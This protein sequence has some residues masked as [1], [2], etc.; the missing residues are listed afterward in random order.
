[1]AASPAACHVVLPAV[2]AADP[3]RASAAARLIGIPSAWVLREGRAGRPVVVGS[4][5]GAVAARRSAEPLLR[6]GVP[7]EVVIPGAGAARTGLL[8]VGVVI[9]LLAAGAALPAALLSGLGT[10]AVVFGLGVAFAAA[11]VV[12]G[13][14]ALPGAPP[15]GLDDAIARRDADQAR[16]GDV[17]T[18]LAAL[19][20]TLNDTDLPPDAAIELGAEL[21]RLGE[22]IVAEHTPAEARAEAAVALHDIAA[23]L[24]ER[25]PDPA[26]LPERV[27]RIARMARA[28]AASRDALP[29]A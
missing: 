27:A 8:A 16:F 21:T 28:A 2:A 23:A 29:P 14:R 22:R 6:A 17:W 11:L 10:A 24:T 4:Y 12:L 7:A 25:A 3:A 19:D 26:D 13:G 9:G 5:P 18:A 15:A 1:M 20:R